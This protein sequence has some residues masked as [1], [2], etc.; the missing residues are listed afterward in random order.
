MYQNRQNAPQQPNYGSG[1]NPYQ[2]PNYGNSQNAYQ[3]PDYGNAQNMNQQPNYGNSQNAYQQPNYGNGQNPYQQPNYGNWQGNPYPQEQHGPVS[4]VLC[5]IL[6]VI[7][8]AQIIIN[9]VVFGATWN[10][11]AGEG[12]DAYLD[13]SVSLGSPVQMLSMFSNLLFVDACAVDFGYY[14]NQQSEIQDHRSG[15]V[16]DFLKTGLLHLESTCA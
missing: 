6:L 14:K 12:I 9:F 7:F 11:M 4:D 8:M 2:Q 1:Q 16:C 5:N 13:G 15:V 3:Q 10:A